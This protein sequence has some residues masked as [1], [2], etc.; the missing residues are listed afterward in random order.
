MLLNKESILAVDDIKTE[1]VSVPEWGGD[2]KIRAMSVKE[3][4]DFD[5]YLS[6]NTDHRDMAF[7]LV[8]KC[9]V[10]ESG[11]RLFTDNDI[12]LLHKKSSKPLMRIVEAIMSLNKQRDGD[13]EELAKN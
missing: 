4:L 6:K 1:I 10:D 9:C 8:V 11:D 12:E 5:E 2:V 3:Q 13:V 7:Y